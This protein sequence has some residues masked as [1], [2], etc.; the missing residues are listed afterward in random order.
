MVIILVIIHVQLLQFIC[1]LQYE[2]QQYWKYGT[3][4]N[5]THW[6]LYNM[7]WTVLGYFNRICKSA[8]TPGSTK[9]LVHEWG[10]PDMHRSDPTQALR[11]PIVGLVP[12]PHICIQIFIP[13]ALFKSTESKM[14]LKFSY[15]YGA[16]ILVPQLNA[17]FYR[18]LHPAW[19][20]V[21]GY[22]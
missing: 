15:Y 14:I 3:V 5:T 22:I 18:I 13:R 4:E 1:G 8:A 17:S 6:V 10:G 9:T 2:T 12:P 21:F 20:N 19:C 16:K 11:I 7:I